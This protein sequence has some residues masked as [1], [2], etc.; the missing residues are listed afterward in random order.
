M[1]SADASQEESITGCTVAQLAV[2]TQPGTA[3]TETPQALG[4]SRIAAIRLFVH[5]L[6]VSACLLC[7]A[8]LR[9]LPRSRAWPWISEPL[10]NEDTQDQPRSHIEKEE[11]LRLIVFALECGGVAVHRVVACS[12]FSARHRCT[13][14][15]PGDAACRIA[16]CTSHDGAVVVD[17]VARTLVLDIVAP[18]ACV[19]AVTVVTCVAVGVRPAVVRIGLGATANISGRDDDQPQPLT[20]RDLQVMRTIGSTSA[21]DLPTIIPA[22]S[23]PPWILLAAEA[24]GDPASSQMTV[25]LRRRDE[26]RV[27]GVERFEVVPVVDAVMHI[28]AMIV[29]FFLRDE[30]GA[31]GIA[32]RV[33]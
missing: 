30:A 14:R 9:L 5:V 13:H 29:E 3:D 4:I 7:L 23:D 1:A 11:H 17:C 28:S 32:E 26:A 22:N 19:R 24:C 20:A 33:K 12:G 10:A 2:R 27:I 25:E 6:G 18:E 8:V 21:R 15:C 16:L 31:V